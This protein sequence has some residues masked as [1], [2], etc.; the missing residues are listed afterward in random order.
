[1]DIEGLGIKIVEQLVDS[2]LVK[3]LA[4]LYDLSMKDL[5]ALEGFKEKKAQ[6]LL[7]AIAA[8]KRQSLPRL[9]T[10]IGIPG[11]GE[12]MA[13]DLAAEFG[14]LEALQ[15][16]SR[17]RLQEIAGVG[18][19]IAEAIVDWFSRKPNRRLLERFRR[20]GIQPKF[21]RAI[22]PSAASPL[23][24]KTFVLTGVLK[25]YTRGQAKALIEEHGG[26]V[27]GSV[28]KKTDFLVLGEDPGSKLQK[29]KT[30]NIPVLDETAL[31]NMISSKE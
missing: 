27:T 16:A 26:K 22:R 2:G 28:T 9:L 5:L 24:G 4:G 6:N 31:E 19:N 21:S 10:G 25:K 8:S 29:A 17:E 12:V 14:D 15:D 1:M 7:D 11:V 20:Q 23:R 30:L 13:A 18:P 3:D